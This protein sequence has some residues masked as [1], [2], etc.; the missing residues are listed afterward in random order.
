MPTAP[1]SFSLAGTTVNAVFDGAGLVPGDIIQV[2]ANGLRYEKVLSQAE[3][4]VGT[5][6]VVT[7]AGATVFNTA[8]ALIDQAGNASKVAALRIEDFE[9]TVPFTTTAYSTKNFGLFDF[10]WSTNV[11]ANSAWFKN[12]GVEIGKWRTSNG[13]NAAF[14]DASNIGKG[15]PIKF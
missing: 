8:V 7:A 4:T 12:I 1:L 14:L 11:M 10:S 9:S 15:S 13:L 6:G 2:V 3:I 5:A